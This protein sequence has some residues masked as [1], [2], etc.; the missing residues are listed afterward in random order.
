MMIMHSLIGIHSLLQAYCYK[1]EVLNPR[2]GVLVK[3]TF[4][5][6]IPLIALQNSTISVVEKFSA[7]IDEGPMN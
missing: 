4:S 6:L 1:P 5:E 7:I 2:R 3:F